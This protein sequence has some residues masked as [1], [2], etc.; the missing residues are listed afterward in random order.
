MDYTEEKLR[1]I[2]RYEGIIVN[3]N[4]DRIRLPDGSESY[5]EV[6][7][8]PGGVCILLVDDDGYAYCVRQYRYPAREHLIEAPAGKLEFG[9]D[10]L[11]CA[12]REL[13]EETG[14]TAGQMIPLGRYFAS[15]GISTEQIHLYLAVKLRRGDAHP[16]VGEFLDLLR[17]PY[18]ELYER[19]LEG[20]LQDG[21]T[22]IAVLQARRYIH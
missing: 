14:F 5:R 7:E 2:N 16:D 18:E 19:V 15:P 11:K 17:I 8:H 1:R 20:D 13:G 6:V 4:M 22:V 10:P 12:V 9:E 3:L 21:K